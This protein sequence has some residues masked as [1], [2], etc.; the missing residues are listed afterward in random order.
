M[1]LTI[2]IDL[3]TRFDST[4]TSFFQWR[5][6]TGYETVDEAREILRDAL[7]GELPVEIRQV[8]E[9]KAGDEYLEIKTLE[10]D[11]REEL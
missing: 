4:C 11:I 6:E 10:V 2:T 8:V 5:D 9:D 1:K 7:E 3:E